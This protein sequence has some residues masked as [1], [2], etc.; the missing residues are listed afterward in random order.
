METIKGPDNYVPL[1]T[2]KSEQ[3]WFTMWSGI[4]PISSRQCSAISGHPLPERM[5]FGPA[6]YS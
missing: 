1:L 2:W 4:L 5:D 6:V 3:Q